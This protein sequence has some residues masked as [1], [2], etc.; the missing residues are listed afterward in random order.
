MYFVNLHSFVVT[1]KS[2]LTLPHVL[3]LREDLLSSRIFPRQPVNCK[4]YLLS[5][6]E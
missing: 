3:I 6:E 1:Y 4:T 5:I 2:V